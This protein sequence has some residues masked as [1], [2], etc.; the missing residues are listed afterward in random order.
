MEIAR[1][2]ATTTA[3]PLPARTGLGDFQSFLRLLTTQMRNQDPLDPID[4]SDYAVQLA[5]FAGVEQQVRTN[6]LLE[7]L[8]SRLAL[9]GLAEIAGW[10]GREVRAAAPA[11]FDG[12]PVTLA[13]RPRPEADAAEIVVRDAQGR[14]VTRAPIGLSGEPVEWAGVAADGA[15]LPRG[16]YRIE[17]ASL[18]RGEVVAVDP[19]E[20]YARVTE[21][22]WE[23]GEA[24]VVLRGGAVVPASA[25]TALRP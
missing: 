17:V 18:V 7:T 10:V 21:V 2:T 5:T 13:A 6:A 20:I 23:G 9:A 4:S 24:A 22:R 14:E 3:P 11:F 15:P 19:A 25:V 12:S 16:A 8:S 1:T